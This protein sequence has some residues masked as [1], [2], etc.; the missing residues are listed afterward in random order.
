MKKLTGNKWFSF[1]CGL[2][3]AINLL[4]LAV[5]TLEMGMSSLAVRNFA[6][7]VIALDL[8]VEA[9]VLSQAWASVGKHIT[10]W[11]GVSAVL[12]VLALIMLLAPLGLDSNL[13]RWFVVSIVSLD[14]AIE[15]YA[16]AKS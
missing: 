12:N 1:W 2:G 10:F 13:V 4:A 15:L 9:Y 11:S 16:F 3:F 8:I 5:L 6:L 7:T 14:T